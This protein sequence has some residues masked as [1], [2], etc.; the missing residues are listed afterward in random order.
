ML[1]LVRHPQRMKIEPHRMPGIFVARSLAPCATDALV[2]PGGAC[3]SD[4]LVYQPGLDQSTAL[5]EELKVPEVTFRSW[6]P[7]RSYTAAAIV[8]GVGAAP[9][10]QDARVLAVGLPALELTYLADLVGQGGAVVRTRSFVVLYCNFRS[11]N[12]PFWG[13]L[14][15]LKRQLKV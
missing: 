1:H 8:C 6:N 4:E 2:V 10:W 12:L 3:F 5:L 15:C 11:L 9:R 14:G 13:L 7:F